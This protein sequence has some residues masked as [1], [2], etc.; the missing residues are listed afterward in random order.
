[1][2]NIRL[3]ASEYPRIS[4]RRFNRHGYAIQQ[5][6]FGFNQELQRGYFK[7][8]YRPP[9]GEARVLD[10]ALSYARAHTIARKHK[11]NHGKLPC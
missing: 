8:W 6:N 3:T 2:P 9:D 10:R 7:I 5:L 4:P 1:M 11:L